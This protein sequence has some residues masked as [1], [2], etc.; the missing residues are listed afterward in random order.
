M[1][2]GHS[3]GGAVITNAATGNANVQSLVYIAAY[4]PDQGDTVVA[5]NALGGGDTASRSI[6][7]LCVRTPAPPTGSLHRPRRSSMRCSP[8]ISA[9]SSGGHGV[10]QRPAA[11]ATL[12]E[13]SGAPAWQRSRAGTSSPR[14]TASSRRGPS[15]SWPQRAGAT[16]IEIDSSHVAMISHPDE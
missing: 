3:Y 13:P 8:G 15:A 11:L 2:V 5:A 6:I 16:T 1:L 12:V 9:R 7:S 4:A 14:R 10:A